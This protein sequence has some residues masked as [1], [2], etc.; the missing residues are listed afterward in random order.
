MLM[1]CENSTFSALLEIVARLRAPDGCPWDR[2]QTAQTFKSYVIEE[3]HELLEAIDAD[4]SEH[5]REELGDLLFQLIFLTRLYE[6]KNLFAM[7]DV[8]RSISEKMIRRHP[9]VFSG[10]EAGSDEEMRRRW[11]EIK[12][13]ERVG[14]RDAPLTSLPRSLPALRRAQRISERA[15]KVDDS[16]LTLAGSMRKLEKEVGYLEEAILQGRGLQT[17]GDLFFT[18]VEICRLAEIN[19]E[20]ALQ[21]ATDRRIGPA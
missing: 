15:A 17:I 20:D 6:E 2:K 21:A 10:L 4:D 13:R 19:A 8:I 7:E 9:H 16:R 3:A 14:K 12:T 5:V 18:M 11:H 1:P